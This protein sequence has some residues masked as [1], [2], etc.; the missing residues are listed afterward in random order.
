MTQIINVTLARH[1]VHVSD[2]LLSRRGHAGGFTSFDRN[3]NKL[4]VV[5]A[6]DG[7]AVLGYTGRAFLGGMSTDRLLAEVAA[8]R[9]IGSG[10]FIASF[11]Q[12]EPMVN[13]GLISLRILDRLNL[14]WS[15]LSSS[16]QASQLEVLLSGWIR[17][18]PIAVPFH[19]SISK[20]TTAVGW[21]FRIYR[22][23]RMWPSWSKF[24][25]SATPDV[26]PSVFELLRKRMREVAVPGV[27]A[28]CEVLRD[29]MGMIANLRPETVGK[30]YMQAILS[31]WES[32]N[33]KLRMTVSRED[34]KMDIP[35]LGFT[36]WI[37]L[38]SG[39]W[40]PS[41]MFS[42]DGHA[43]WTCQSTGFSWTIEGAPLA[44]GGASVRQT[45]QRR[46]KEPRR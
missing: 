3:S 25:I 35:H 16:E 6:R 29:F 24:A 9:S 45:P 14:E 32:P 31:P 1:V 10:D 30:S 8:G 27:E 46:R 19:W 23:E 11:G 33:L 21:Q 36:P 2:R 43:G 7:L 44:S 15:R 40:A 39:V 13:L 12:N 26:E 5:V 4:V 41:E 37:V 20:V 22:F 17:R 38:R 42:R 18:G 34:A 28:T